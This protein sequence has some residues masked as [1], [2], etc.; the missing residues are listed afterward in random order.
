[1]GSFLGDSLNH[2][3]VITFNPGKLPSETMLTT[4]LRFVMLAACTILIACSGEDEALLKDQLTGRWEIVSAKRNNRTTET[5]TDLYF[6]FGPE[7]RL[8]TNL[9][10]QTEQ[11][12]FAL[13]DLQIQQSGTSIETTYDIV[14]ITDSNLELRTNIR[15]Y[16]FDLKLR[17][18]ADEARVE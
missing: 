16:R 6:E 9:I 7:N 17:K 14:S 4:H 2:F 11:G 1:M 15:G 10:G 18:V 8:E 5:L 12:Q 13:S 3:E